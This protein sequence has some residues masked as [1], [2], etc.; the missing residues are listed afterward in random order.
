MHCGES[1]CRARQFSQL[2][3][4]VSI[5]LS[6]LTCRTFTCPLLDILFQSRPKIPGTDQSTGSLPT[7]MAEVVK[8][9]MYFPSKLWW[10]DRARI[11][12]VGVAMQLDVLSSNVKLFILAQIFIGV[13]LLFSNWRQC[14]LASLQ[15]WS[16]QRFFLV[17]EHCERACRR[18][19]YS[20]L[21]HK[22]YR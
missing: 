20:S 8:C 1:L 18:R 6:S 12:L 3:L 17:R 21:Q 7:R 19:H 9:V 15:Q 10:H 14:R 22:Q 11:W 16:Q 4:R 2:S 5:D 13:C